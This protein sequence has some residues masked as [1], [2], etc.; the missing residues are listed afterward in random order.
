MPKLVKQDTFPPSY[1]V[2]V[3]GVL[4]GEVYK[5]DRND[6]AGHYWMPYVEGFDVPLPGEWTRREAVEAVISAPTPAPGGTRH[7]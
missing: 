7:E 2:M 3:D 1:A 5:V 6:Y 4:R